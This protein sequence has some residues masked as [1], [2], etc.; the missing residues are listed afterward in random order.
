MRQA[1]GV[2]AAAGA[3]GEIDCPLGELCRLPAQ[4]N[5]RFTGRKA[6]TMPV[7]VDLG[8]AGEHLRMDGVRNDDAFEALA[9]R[10][11]EIA[12]I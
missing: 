12:T 6:K 2:I 10:R 1:L 8:K 5:N 3:R 4:S 9:N 7:G 11:E